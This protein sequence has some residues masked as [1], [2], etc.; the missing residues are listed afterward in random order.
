MPKLT[1]QGVGEFDVAEG[2]R[3]T[4]A[5]V[6]DAGTDQLHACG[7]QSRC[8]TCRVKFGDGEPQKMTQAEKDTLAARGITDEGIR[9][10]CQITCEHD[11][12]VELVSRFEGSGR[13]DQGTPVADAIEP[14]PVWVEK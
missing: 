6:Q 12:S 9:L 7:G 8:T 5:L 2:K 3:L 10:S 4:S 11:M 13:K 1:V 14:T